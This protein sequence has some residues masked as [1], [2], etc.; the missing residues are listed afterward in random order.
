MPDL[1]DLFDRSYDPPF[2]S[3]GRRSMEEGL[4]AGFP[5]MDVKGRE[6]IVEDRGLHEQDRGLKGPSDPL[7]DNLVRPEP[8]NIFFLPEDPAA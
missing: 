6:D 3:P 1:Q 7:S 8:G 5:V 4:P 2:L